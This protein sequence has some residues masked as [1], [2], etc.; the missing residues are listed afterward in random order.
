MARPSKKRATAI[1]R[2]R[3][4]HRIAL[5]VFVAVAAG[6]LIVTGTISVPRPGLWVLYTALAASAGYLMWA[7]M[8]VMINKRPENDDK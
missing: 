5:L 2:A 7:T 1:G 8:D 3:Q 4:R 6:F